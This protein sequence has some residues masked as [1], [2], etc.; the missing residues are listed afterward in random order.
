MSDAPPP[1]YE[2]ATQSK[3]ADFGRP[4]TYGS[5]SHLDVPRNGIP[6]LHRRSMEDEGRPLPPGWVRQYDAKESHQYFVDTNVSPARAI[7]HHPCDDEQYLSTLSSEER[8]RLEAATMKSSKADIAAESSAEESDPA[9]PN[10][11]PQPKPSTSSSTGPELPERPHPHSQEHNTGGGLGKLGRKMKDKLTATTHEERERA[12]QRRAQ[13]EQEAYQRYQHLRSAMTRAAQTG[14]PQLIG[15]NEQGQDVYIEPPRTDPYGNH[16]YPGSGSHSG[17]RGTYQA[18][19]P[20]TQGPY[21]NPNNRFVA[22]P[23]P[24][25]AYGRPYGNGYGGGMGMPLMGGML[26]GMMLGGLLF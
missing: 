25:Y 9:S 2:D 22:H 4:T 14:Q 10:K 1:A 17:G 24:D 8:E 7:W 19:N 18:Y 21:A 3:K 11:H 12:R 20:Y 16:V 15:K 26:G 23:R 13:E 6:T 5:S